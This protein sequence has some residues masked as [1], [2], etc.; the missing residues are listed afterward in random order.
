MSEHKEPPFDAASDEVSAQTVEAVPQR[1]SL[2]DV[3]REILEKNGIHLMDDD[4]ILAVFTINEALLDDLNA[5][6]AHH[7]ARG[8]QQVEKLRAI[9]SESTAVFAEALDGALG[10]IDQRA[11]A[12]SDQLEKATSDHVLAQ[13]SQLMVQLGTILQKF[14]AYSHTFTFLTVLLLFAVAVFLFK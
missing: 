13:G 3:K 14:K 1:H 12:L 8:A 6:L 11:E 5:L 10:K 2:Q 4:P 9:Q 7:A